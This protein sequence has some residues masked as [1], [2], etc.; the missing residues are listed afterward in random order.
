MIVN[1]A[2]A[3]SATIS[4]KGC[5]CALSCNLDLKNSE[6]HEGKIGISID[7]GTV[8]LNESKSVLISKCCRIH[9]VKF[10]AFHVI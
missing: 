1:P 6:T 8:L 9:E 3:V 4:L 2:S 10:Y 7:K 5:F